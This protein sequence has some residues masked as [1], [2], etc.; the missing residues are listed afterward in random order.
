MC[1]SQACDTISKLKSTPTL[2]QTGNVSLC[3]VDQVQ[4]LSHGRD[5][6]FVT[7]IVQSAIGSPWQRNDTITFT[8]YLCVSLYQEFFVLNVQVHM[9]LENSATEYCKLK[10]GRMFEDLF[11]SLPCFQCS[12][13]LLGIFIDDWSWDCQI[14]KKNLF[15]GFLKTVKFVRMDQIMCKNSNK[16]S[17]MQVNKILLSC[18][19]PANF[20]YVNVF[21]L[22]FEHVR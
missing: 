8:I 21:S 19:F 20:N 16:S 22:F 7:S 10:S 17:W 11:K 2:A 18:L 1:F 5:Q 13:N 9:K 14:Y 15:S 6:K 12:W 3:S 4:C